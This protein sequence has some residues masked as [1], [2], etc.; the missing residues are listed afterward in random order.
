MLRRRTRDARAA[1]H[2]VS[3]PELILERGAAVEPHPRPGEEE[4]AWQPARPPLREEPHL[5]LGENASVDTQVRQEAP[6]LKRQRGVVAHSE[7]RRVGQQR[8]HR[9]LRP[10]EPRPVRQ[11]APAALIQEIE[12]RM[13]A[14]GAVVIRQPEPAPPGEHCESR[15]HRPDPVRRGPSRD[16]LKLIGPGHPIPPCLRPTVG[17]GS[18]K[19]D[20]A[21][22]AAAHPGRVHP[23]T[24]RHQGSR[25]EGGTGDDAV[26]PGSEIET[27]GATPSHAPARPRSPVA[28]EPDPACND[29]ASTSLLPAVRPALGSVSRVSVCRPSVVGTAM[30]GLTVA[31]CVP[32]ARASAVPSI[33]GTKAPV[34][35]TFP[36]VALTIDHLVTSTT[37][38]PVYARGAVSFQR[39]HSTLA[40]RNWWTSSTNFGTLLPG[41]PV[42]MRST[43]KG[44]RLP[45]LPSGKRALSSSS[46]T[47]LTPATGPPPPPP[48]VST[49]S[50]PASSF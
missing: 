29:T 6:P 5:R 40:A 31:V 45:A 32:S 20:A 9:G 38:P 35:R 28:G 26:R 13:V 48:P 37:A 16:E 4:A 25:R 7:L 24:D 1:R 15:R 47:R 49:V 43:G 46:G 39:S 33:T 22:I 21:R 14:E 36:V 23:D 18:A 27:H 3:T 12:R 30:S 10:R 41:V 42:E 17:G 44:N 2:A 19:Q 11:H 34:M 50:S 8:A